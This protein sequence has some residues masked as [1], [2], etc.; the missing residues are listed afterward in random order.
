MKIQVV[1]TPKIPSELKPIYKFFVEQKK[2]KI[3]E[4]NT[5]IFE[6]DEKYLNEKFYIN[7]EDY[8]KNSKNSK[9]Y[10]I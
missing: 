10:K 6:I 1:T 8:M 9:T 4:N 3:Y 5:G 7:I 2:L